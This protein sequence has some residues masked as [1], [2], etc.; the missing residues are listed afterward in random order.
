MF[1][2]N[3]SLDISTL[4]SFVF[5]MGEFLKISTLGQFIRRLEENI[6]ILVDLD[7]LDII[8][9]KTD[10]TFMVHVFVVSCSV[11]YIFLFSLKI[12]KF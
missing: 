11:S 9:D 7:E 8:M 10:E 3:L 5:A 2:V 4:M 6:T 12:Y 1:V